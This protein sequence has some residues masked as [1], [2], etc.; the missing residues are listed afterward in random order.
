MIIV[1]KSKVMRCNFSR[2]QEPL[3]VRLDGVEHE[4]EN[5]LNYLGSSVCAYEKVGV[6]VKIG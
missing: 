6:E 3:K 1:G 5:E 2:E 4:A